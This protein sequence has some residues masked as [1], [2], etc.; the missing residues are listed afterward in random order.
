MRTCSHR[1]AFHSATPSPSLCTLTLCGFR[2]GC[3]LNFLR[4][5]STCRVIRTCIHY[6][7]ALI[8]IIFRIHVAGS[9]C[10]C[11]VRGGF[12]YARICQERKPVCICVCVQTLICISRPMEL[13]RRGGRKGSRLSPGSI[14]GA[15]RSHNI[16]AK[17]IFTL[18]G[19]RFRDSDGRRQHV[20]G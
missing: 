17:T 4:S 10:E 18:S 20:F 9:A 2:F 8:L 16:C 12:I 13:E 11:V 14:G 7:F 19:G 1:C 15:S 3:V 6:K 5:Y